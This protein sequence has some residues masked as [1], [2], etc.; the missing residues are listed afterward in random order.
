MSQHELASP[1]L[2][3]ATV[4]SSVS[5]ELGYPNNRVDASLEPTGWLLERD[6]YFTKVGGNAQALALSFES[7][8]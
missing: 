4:E 7:G 1:A 2:A 3:E 5:P 6:N 8:S